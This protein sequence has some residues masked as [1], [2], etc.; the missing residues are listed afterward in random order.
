MKE[1]IRLEEEKRGYYPG[2]FDLLK[3][4]VIFGIIMAHFSG[5]F[6]D[7]LLFGND[8]SLLRKSIGILLKVPSSGATL[9]VLFLISG[10]GFTAIGMKKCVK[11]QT[12]QLLKPYILTGATVAALHLAVHSCTFHYFP[13]AARQTGMLILSHLL[14][15]QTGIQ[16]GGIQLCS[17]G[18]VWFLLALFEGWVLITFVRNYLPGRFHAFLSVF[19][20]FSSFLLLAVAP[21]WVN[22][23]FCFSYS[24]LCAGNLYLGMQM[25]KHNLLWK[26]L[27]PVIWF[28]IALFAVFANINMNIPAVHPVVLLIALCVYCIG[29]ECAAFLLMWVF[30]RINRW[31]NWLFDK[32]RM[33]GRYSLWV[34]CAHTIESQ[35]LLWYLFAEKWGGHEFD[36]FLTMALI[37]SLL[38]FG[39]CYLIYLWN[40]RKLWKKKLRR[41]S[42]CMIK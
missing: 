7:E 9:P 6:P 14:G 13:G 18:S 5:L 31:N 21:P 32:F 11:K 3:G 42:E 35:G 8:S 37:R 20:I 17:V 34:L 30:V 26:R 38:I 39:I 12:K 27:S 36:T 4:V 28:L 40:R 2:M 22:Y 29:S 41:T 19:F 24:L 33:V 16:I 1:G 23:P 10:F 25:R 15:L